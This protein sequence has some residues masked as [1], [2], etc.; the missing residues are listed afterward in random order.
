MTHS[1]LPALLPPHEDEGRTHVLALQ[2]R[3]TDL[4]K[5]VT[6]HHCVIALLEQRMR[7]LECGDAAGTALEG[8]VMLE[9]AGCAAARLETEGGSLFLPVD[10]QLSS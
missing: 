6:Q 10:P 2:R 7:R 1:Q 9:A 5:Q 8:Q 4:E 3:V